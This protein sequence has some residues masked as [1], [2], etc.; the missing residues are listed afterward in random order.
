MA[1]S[2][3]AHPTSHHLVVETVFT[4]S[5]ANTVMGS[6][7]ARG[8]TAATPS[9]L[10]VMRSVYTLAEDQDVTFKGRRLEGMPGIREYAE[11]WLR[12]GQQIVSQA[13]GRFRVIHSYA[14]KRNYVE[15][16]V[17]DHAIGSRHFNTVSFFGTDPLP[18]R[19]LYGDPAVRFVQE[20][21]AKPFAAAYFDAATGRFEP[22]PHPV[23]ATLLPNFLRRFQQVAA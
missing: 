17:L 1:Q 5:L 18:R 21:T 22:I 13:S 4:E 9:H 23:R 8:V 6:V 2:V 3:L 10:Q 12:P 14:G 20:G 11:E 19:H 16:K 15:G 7:K